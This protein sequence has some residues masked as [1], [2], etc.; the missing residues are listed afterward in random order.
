M[1]PVVNRDCPYV[2]SCLLYHSKASWNQDLTL[3]SFYVHNLLNIVNDS[4]SRASY[5]GTCLKINS[6][7]FKTGIFYLSQSVVDLRNSF[8]PTPANLYVCLLIETQK[9]QMLSQYLNVNK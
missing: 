2:F 9:M 7:P 5:R 6:H 1:A 8:P 3:H 4:T